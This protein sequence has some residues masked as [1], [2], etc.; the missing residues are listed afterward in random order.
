MAT[1]PILV[2]TDVRRKGLE[3]DRGSLKLRLRHFR[4]R[5]SPMKVF[6]LQAPVYRGAALASRL[7]AKTSEIAAVGRDAIA[8]WQRA[9]A[10]GLSAEEAARCRGCPGHPVSLEQ[11][12]R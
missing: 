11:A 1:L 2:Q 7:T 4:S 8:R 6:G 12:A 3:R 9:R 10:N 5:R